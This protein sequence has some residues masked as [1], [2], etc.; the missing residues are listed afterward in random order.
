M[1]KHDNP[2]AS[3]D[4]VELS[5]AEIQVLQEHLRRDLEELDMPFDEPAA[6]KIQGIFSGI[7]E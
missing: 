1:N 3:T 5:P 6:K 4:V 2:W 7:Y